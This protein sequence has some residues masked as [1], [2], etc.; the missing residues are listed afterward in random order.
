MLKKSTNSLTYRKW[1]QPDILNKKW[2]IALS[3]I[4]ILTIVYSISHRSISENNQPETI[5]TIA[6]LPLRITDSDEDNQSLSAGIMEDILIR[7][8]H[9]EGLMVKSRISAEK[10]GNYDMTIPEIAQEMNVS[11]VLGGT[12]LKEN[13]SI[14]IY[15]TLHDSNGNYIWSEQY[16][17]NIVGILNFISDVSGQIAEALKNVLS[18]EDIKQLERVYTYN[19]EAYRL[20]QLGRFF[21][22]QMDSDGSDKSIY[23][24]K[25]ALKTDSTFALAYA[26]LADAYYIAATWNWISPNDGFSKG[27]EYAQKALSLDNNLAN[28]HAT[29]G[30]IA[31]FYECNW[32]NAKNKL[33]KA[34][35]LN[36]NYAVSYRYYA[37][38]LTILGQFEEARNYIKKAINLDPTAKLYYYAASRISYF[39]EQFDISIIERNKAL[40]FERYNTDKKFLW[41]L[42]LT[43]IHSK[44]D[45][46]AI[47]EYIKTAKSPKEK[48][49]LRQNLLKI[50]SE[51]GMEGLAFYI[52]SEGHKIRRPYATAKLFCLA[53]KN[54]SAIVYLEKAF[55]EGRY[56]PHIKVTPE[57]KTLRDN[58][59]FIALLEKVNLAEN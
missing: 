17:K 2:V 25:E 42:F 50:N 46:L 52:A 36:P 31:I 15:I 53:G 9:V 19:T 10:L 4:L 12:L 47:V 21:W 6:V 26:G 27:K 35:Q 44:K 56:Y 59:R 58:P 14:R 43:Y 30:G 29:L 41:H 49:L 23:Y 40:E 7:L 22:C 5:K 13:N 34:I 20:Y 3:T 45:S 1:Y 33:Q 8:S 57:F 16:N 48:E 38:Y 39:A 37:E 32:K 11:Y 24:F 51:S 54:D 28:A 55:Q 18:P